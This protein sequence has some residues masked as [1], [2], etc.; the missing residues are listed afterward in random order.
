MV[1]VGTVVFAGIFF[2]S[3]YILLRIISIG[4]EVHLIA[5]KTYYFLILLLLPLLSFSAI[6]IFIENLLHKETEFLFT[7]PISAKHLYKKLFKE[8]LINSCLMPFIF[9]IAAFL[10]WIL[11]SH[12]YILTLFLF[13][14]N[15]ISLFFI[16]T[17]IGAMV[18][19]YISKHFKIINSK[20]YLI[21]LS[22]L[23]IVTLTIF[24]RLLRPERLVNA[25]I[26]LKIVDFLKN[27]N[28]PVINNL[29]FVII[30]LSIKLSIN[31]NFLKAAQLTLYFIGFAIL[32]YF[33]IK[34]YI[35]K[36]LFYI[37]KKSFE[38]K[39]TE[40]TMVRDYSNLIK[41]MPFETKELL[42][43]KRDPAL[44][45]QI[46]II[47]GIIFLFAY[48]LYVLPVKNYFIKVILILLSCS[49]SGAI[50]ATLAGRFIFTSFQREQK[51]LTFL[52]TLPIKFD[53]ILY[54]KL[55]LYFCLMLILTMGFT[56]LSNLILKPG[57]FLQAISIYLNIY[58]TTGVAF[59]STGLGLYFTKPYESNLLFSQGGIIY[60]CVAFLF[61]AITILITSAGFELFV[62]YYK[63]LSFR[64][65]LY[66]TLLLIAL[67]K[68]IIMSII[69]Y[70]PLSLAYNKLEEIN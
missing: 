53:K 18:A 49:V 51:A 43:I 29:P 15:I 65:L 61:I 59:L 32:I 10:P 48:N 33:S 70:V 68:L 35:T 13:L 8:A 17:S 25:N 21:A 46:I 5:L 27:L 47:C 69:I 16:T 64:W 3:R 24:I 28:P 52:K 41:L 20:K 57:W 58:I 22:I 42:I 40:N 67:T 63:I 23:L 39:H 36:R 2:L 1:G 62:V 44:F 11:Y 45:S 56:I 34:N 54:K 55:G 26:Q 30:P 37:I 50:I 12:N 7:F 60:M 6:I 66:I 19:T 4:E 31:K 38:E 9:I 14:L